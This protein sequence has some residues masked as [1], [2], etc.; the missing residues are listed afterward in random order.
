MASQRIPIGNRRRDIKQALIVNLKQFHSASLSKIRPAQPQSSRKIHGH[1]TAR[2]SKEK[3][4]IFITLHPFLFQFS[5]FCEITAQLS[6]TL[7]LNSALFQRPNRIFQ[8]P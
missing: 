7:S 6:A 8:V 4:L 1:C 2:N 3:P 5:H